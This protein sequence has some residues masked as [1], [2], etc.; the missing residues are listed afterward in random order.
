MHQFL[1][2]ICIC[3][4][5]VHI[6]IY[7][8]YSLYLIYRLGIDLSIHLPIYLPYPST[9]SSIYPTMHPSIHLS[10]YRSIDRCLVLFLLIYRVPSTHNVTWVYVGCMLEALSRHSYVWRNLSVHSFIQVAATRLLVRCFCT[11]FDTR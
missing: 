7:T 9:H 2:G 4:Y 1:C 3:I 6:H 5:T 10:T 11:L 8:F